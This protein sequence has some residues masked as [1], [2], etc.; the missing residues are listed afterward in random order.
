[1]IQSYKKHH[2]P[3]V[4]GIIFAI[5]FTIWAFSIATNQAFIRSFDQAI[6][7]IVYNNNKVNLQIAR[8]LTNL[9]NTSTITIEAII[10]FIALLTFKKYPL[11]FFEA[12]VMICGNACNWIIKNLVRRSRPSVQHLVHADG[13]SFPSGHSLGSMTLFG[14][15]FVITLL[16][17]KNK[18]TKIILNILWCLFPL[19]IGYTRIYL[20]VHY[21]SDVFGG[22]IEGL[23]FVLIGYAIL[24]RSYVTKHPQKFY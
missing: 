6:I 16:L 9:G 14:C 15:L 3:L 4:I 20:H 2:D 17:V 8:L 12:G 13:F 11:A 10:I 19:I 1:M 21:P 18:K 7:N 23:A 24:L 5:I 22:W